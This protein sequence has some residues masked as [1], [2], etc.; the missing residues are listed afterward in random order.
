[1]PRSKR[2]DE[3]GCIYH[4]MNRGNN[5]NEIF[6]KPEDYLAFLRVLR[7]GL[8]KYPVDLFAFCLMPNHWHLVVRP[9][10]DG[11]MGKLLGWVTATHTL[12]HHAHYHTDGGGHLYQGPFKS[13]PV[14]DD[15]HFLTVCRYVECNAL[16]A[17]L[18]DR[19]EDWEFGSLSRWR[20]KRDVDP[21]LLTAWPIRRSP[22]WTDRVNVPLTAS[23]LNAVRT[24]VAR[25]RPFG[26]QEWTEKTCERTGLWSTVRPRGRPRK[27][28]RVK[29]AQSQ[30]K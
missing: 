6:H 26:D 19:A 25:G 9:Q 7:E 8:D 12:R 20:F 4:A 21:T 17:K 30:P 23:E 15:A 16:H 1:M 14:A 18:V 27:K 24:C 3:A 22:G 11:G 2:A 28:R 10:K 13:F 5:R 29:S